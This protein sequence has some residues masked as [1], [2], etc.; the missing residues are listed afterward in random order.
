VPGANPIGD[1]AVANEDRMNSCAEESLDEKSGILIGA[2]KIG[3]RAE[4]STFAES[5]AIA[6]EPRR[7]G[8]EADALSLEGLERVY[9]SGERRV[10]LVGSEKL[11]ASYRFLFSDAPISPAGFFENGG[12]LFGSGERL[13][14]G[15]A[16]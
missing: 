11:G 14:V 4:N 7:R 10:G 12:S 13:L 1:I 8:S 16:S 6:E 15:S 9:P 5:L 3:K 2:K